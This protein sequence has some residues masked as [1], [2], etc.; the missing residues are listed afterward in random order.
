MFHEMTINA[1]LL[2]QPLFGKTNIRG[3]FSQGR[4]RNINVELFWLPW[5]LLLFFFIWQIRPNFYY[6]NEKKWGKQNHFCFKLQPAKTVHHS[7]TLYQSNSGEKEFSNWVFLRV[8]W[9]EFVKN[10]LLVGWLVGW[11]PVHSHNLYAFCRDI[12]AAKLVKH[13]QL[14]AQMKYK[15]MLTSKLACTSMHL[16][17]KIFYTPG[18]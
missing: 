5:K 8:Y 3:V 15:C 12:S 13:L 6:L 1:V 10:Y 18:F 2:G 7:P 16:Y 9:E 14:H 11:F 4:Q 17:F